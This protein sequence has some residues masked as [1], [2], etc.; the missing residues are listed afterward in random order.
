MI[1]SQTPLRVSFLGG[2]TDIA[3]YYRQYGGAVVSTTIDKYIYIM[4]KS[5]YDDY[6]VL[7]YSDKETVKNPG[8]VKHRIIREA[9]KLSGIESAL[10]ITCVADIP[11]SGSGLGSSSAFTVGLLNALFAYKGQFMNQAELAEMACHIEIQRLQEPIGKQDQYATAFGGFRFYEFRPDGSVKN[12]KIPVDYQTGQNLNKLSLLF[13]TGQ[14]RKAATI[15]KDQKK[16]TPRNLQ[17]LHRLKEL[18]ETGQQYLAAGNLR[19]L[20]RLL[21]A[22]WDLKKGLSRHINNAETDNIYRLAKKNGAWGGKLLGAGG[23]GFLFFL[24]PLEKQNVLRAALRSYYELPFQY[25][26]YGSRIILN[27]KDS[28]GLITNTRPVTSD[29]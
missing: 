8:E 28:H 26:P 21:D 24:C 11:S 15:L 2:G 16:N 22:N 4:V 18:A 10:E 13:F 29:S 7:N 12:K 1:I 5:R 27:I 19:E 20:G 9:L 17:N 14:V 6:L 3:D 25:D 23:G